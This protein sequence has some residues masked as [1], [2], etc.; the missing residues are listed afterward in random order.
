[1]KKKKRRVRPGRLL[2]VVLVL[3]ALIGASVTVLIKV[4][5]PSDD[6]YVF[7]KNSLSINEFDYSEMKMLDIDLYS[8][9]DKTQ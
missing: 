9:A 4:I 6:G 5:G 3:L 2:I 8:N 7:D 1:M